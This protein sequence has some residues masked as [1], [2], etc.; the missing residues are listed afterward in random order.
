MPPP[1][2]FLFFG[3][4]PLGALR[5]PPRKALRALRVPRLPRHNSEKPTFFKKRAFHF[6]LRP[7]ADVACFASQDMKEFVH[8]W[9][10]G[11]LG[12]VRELVGLLKCERMMKE[13]IFNL[14]V[15]IEGEY[16]RSLGVVSHYVKGDEQEKRDQQH[17]L[18]VKEVK[19][20]DECLTRAWGRWELAC[21]SSGYLR[22]LTYPHVC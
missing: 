13:K 17:K 21:A 11:S 4:P 6:A 12:V 9:P 15:Y 18:E 20:V 10:P 2:G 14:F 3:R 19:L 5:Q 1:V 8:S 22:I 16:V 7:H